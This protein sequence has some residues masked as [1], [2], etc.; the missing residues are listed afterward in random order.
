[1]SF[2]LAP[3]L[4]LPPELPGGAE[5][6]LAGR[7]LWWVYAAA[8]AAV[9]LTLLVFG[10]GWGWRLAGTLL[11]M[12][13]HLVGAPGPGWRSLP[14]DAHAFAIGALAAGAAFWLSLGAATG[15]LL[16]R[17]RQL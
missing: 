9:G 8:G 13:P 17:M 7:Q 6:A 3:A 15:A 5:M 14:P 12:V 10:R 11:A 1:V 4:G 16:T 2:A